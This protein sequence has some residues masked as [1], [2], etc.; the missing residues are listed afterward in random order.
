MLQKFI[1]ALKLPGEK[2]YKGSMYGGFFSLWLNS[3]EHN[4]GR[5]CMSAT[6]TGTPSAHGLSA[7]H[8]SKRPDGK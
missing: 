6:E 2:G 1:L 5:T 3:F 7:W 8:P 4:T